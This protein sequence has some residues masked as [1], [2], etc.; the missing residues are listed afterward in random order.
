M[1]FGKCFGPI[2]GRSGIVTGDRRQH[3]LLE[4]ILRFLFRFRRTVV[5]SGRR[6]IIIA[7]E[8]ADRPPHGGSARCQAFQ[9]QAVP[10]P[11]RT[12]ASRFSQNDILC[13]VVLVGNDLFDLSVDLYR[14]VFG[15]VAVLRDLAAEKYL[16]FLFTKCQR[17]QIRTFRIRKPS[18]GR[19]RSLSRY[20]LRHRS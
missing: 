8:A 15:I 18:H 7:V 20:R 17:A 13:P 12:S 1:P 19:S 16:L 2:S 5:I 11:D 3:R 6:R 14:R 9:I 4:R 10:R